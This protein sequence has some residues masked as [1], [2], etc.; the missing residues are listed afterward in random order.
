MAEAEVWCD[1]PGDGEVVVVEYKTGA[2]MLLERDDSNAE[3]AR[4]WWREHLHGQVGPYSWPRVLD[5]AFAV[6]EVELVAEHDRG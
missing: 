5:G 1:E 2:R 6:Y 4:R 3:G